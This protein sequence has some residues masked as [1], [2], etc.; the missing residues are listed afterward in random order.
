MPKQL[1]IFQIGLIALPAGLVAA[2]PVA[3]T[4]TSG[5]SIPKNIIICFML[6]ACDLVCGGVCSGAPCA[7]WFSGRGH[8][9]YYRRRTLL[10]LLLLAAAGGDGG[11]G[12]VTGARVRAMIL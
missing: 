3:N 2:G 6:I 11:G 10:L 12:G 9:K 4:R 5:T 8:V 1:S 7:D